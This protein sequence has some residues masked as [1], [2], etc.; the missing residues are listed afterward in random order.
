MEAYA[1]NDWDE[2]EAKY[3]GDYDEPDVLEYPLSVPHHEAATPGKRASE[4]AKRAKK[5]RE[6]KRR[7]EMI[8]KIKKHERYISR[9][10]FREAVLAVIG[11]VLVA[12]VFSVILY[13]QSQITLQ[14]YRNNEL[15]SE[16]NALREKTSQIKEN[17]IISTDME[18]I[19]WAAMERL[20]MQTPSVQ[21]VITIEIPGKD[22]LVTNDFESTSANS[23]IGL[24]AAKQNLAQYYSD[25][26]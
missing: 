6:I 16:I 17:L 8:R 3:F 5:I 18:Q 4:P 9:K 1:I 10:R 19:R 24:A 25:L 12:A 26:L 23:K 20:G 22:Q 11:I 15:V 13:R 2:L 14:N 7:N 21:Q